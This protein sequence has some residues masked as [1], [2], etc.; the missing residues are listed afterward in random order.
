MTS[1]NDALQ[2]IQRIF[3][4]QFLDDS[5]V[6]TETTSPETV[7]A[8]DSMAQVGLL[9]AVETEFDLQFTADEMGSIASVADLVRALQR[10]GRVD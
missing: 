7:D 4:D 2:R 9:A 1:R 8:W 3:R 6:V 5:L 10:H